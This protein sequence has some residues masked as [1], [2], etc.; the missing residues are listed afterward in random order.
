MRDLAVDAMTKAIE[1]AQARDD[2]ER[3][4]RAAGEIAHRLRK[5]EEAAK[6]QAARE[7]CEAIAEL[8]AGPDAQSLLLCVARQNT[9]RDF[10]P[11]IELVKGV[12]LCSEGLVQATGNARSLCSHWFLQDLP[13][14]KVREAIQARLAEFAVTGK[15]ERVCL[16]GPSEEVSR[17]RSLA[18]IAAVGA[19]SVPLGLLAF[20]AVAPVLG[21]G[22]LLGSLTASG[23]GYFLCQPEP[24]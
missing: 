22:L 4:A 18:A 24:E 2:A 23:V 15:S 16:L 5:A 21:A 1:V 13:A 8:V 9:S 20:G 6:A 19:V 7:N 17:K 10:M 12:Y 3:E 14:E 11:V